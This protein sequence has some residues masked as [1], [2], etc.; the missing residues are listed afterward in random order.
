MKSKEDLRTEIIE[1]G[2]LS[3]IPGIPLFLSYDAH[4]LDTGEVPRSSICNFTISA[5]RFAFSP[6]KIE[7]GA[8]EE[9]I[10]EGD[11]LEGFSAMPPGGS[12]DQRSYIQEIILEVLILHIDNKN[13]PKEL[14]NWYFN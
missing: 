5:L 10:V 4:C 11:V 13:L 3:S 12:D 2:R 14:Y 1:K 9:I 8:N 6:I 7:L